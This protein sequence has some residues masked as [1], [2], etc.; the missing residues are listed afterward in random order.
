MAAKNHLPPISLTVSTLT[1]K[2]ISVRSPWDHLKTEKILN[3]L[4]VAK[5]YKKYRQTYPTDKKNQP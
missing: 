2:K 5:D 3:T 1:S 4:D